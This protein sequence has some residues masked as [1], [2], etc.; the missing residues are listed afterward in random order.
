MD[1]QSALAFLR[2]HQPM[3]P[4]PLISKELLDDYQDALEFFIKNPDAECVPLFLK[5]FGERDLFGNYSRVYE[6]LRNLP[7]EKVIPCI[8][9]GLASEFR[10]VRYWNAQLAQD[11][12]DSSFIDG[13]A[14][15]LQEDD[16]DN[17]YAA[18]S[19]L[20]EIG[21]PSAL[22]VLSDALSHEQDA[23]IRALLSEE[24]ARISSK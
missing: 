22:R 2:S 14:L 16:V 13:L 9:E 5:S 3:P 15:L 10:S 20:S 11:F 17:R 19:A 1:K 12:P 21:S 24:I 7:T 8:R 18:V 6:A 23:E 4:D